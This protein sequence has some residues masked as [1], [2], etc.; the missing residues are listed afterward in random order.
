MP[1]PMVGRTPAQ[2]R[3]QARPLLPPADER[4]ERSSYHTQTG[5]QKRLITLDGANGSGATGCLRWGPVEV[6][7]VSLSRLALSCGIYPLNDEPLQRG[8]GIGGPPSSCAAEQ[9]PLLVKAVSTPQHPF[10]LT[11]V[12]NPHYNCEI[13]RTSAIM[14]SRRVFR[15]LVCMSA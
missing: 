13:Q 1:L 4:R 3:I 2:G 7:R 10:P 11:T 12:P 5:R 14:P 9:L 6:R 8:E 15:F